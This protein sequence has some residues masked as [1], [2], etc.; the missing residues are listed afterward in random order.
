M[1]G[2]LADHLWIGGANGEEEPAVWFGPPA[3]LELSL[4]DQ[5]PGNLLP[6]GLDAVVALERQ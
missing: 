5:N 1:S 6:E 4:R 2:F 3:V